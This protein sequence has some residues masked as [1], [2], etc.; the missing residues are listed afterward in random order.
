M[1]HHRAGFANSVAAME[2]PRLVRLDGVWGAAFDLMKLLPARFILDRAR[3]AGQLEPGVRV[4]ETTSGTFGLG[5][6]IV[7]SL[8]GHAL[9]IVG[10]PAI[11][12][13]LRRRL[14]DL[15]AEVDIVT[16]P[17]DVGGIQAA[18]LARV[19]QLQERHPAHFTP[20]QYEN[21][22]NRIA[23][24]AVAEL[25]LE[26]LG[27]IDFVVGTV[28]SGGSTGGTTSFLRLVCP[29]L[30]LIGVD[31]TNSVLFG[32]PDG[33]RLLRGLGSSIHPGNV[34]PSDYDEIHW[35]GAATAFHATRL[36]H[37]RHG[38][39]M[40][41]TSGAAWLVARWCAER[42]PGATVVALLPDQGWRYLDT[43][44]DDRWLEQ[45]AVRVTRL[46]N[47]PTEVDHPAAVSGEWSRLAWRRRSLAD[48]RARRRA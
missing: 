39:F 38:L 7:C 21:P 6:A 45:R 44:Y 15:G 11:D 23:Y 41:G 22:Y 47:S 33:P 31:T 36:L 42:N 3:E 27:S 13:R 16:S 9:T 17:A 5:L 26:T 10:D 19:A 43:V 29:D 30:Q 35:V 25:L 40:G 34:D 28:G 32:P 18:R 24:G 14:E 48:V 2:L 4:I 37:R 1:A 46:P 12:A 8:Y 20:E